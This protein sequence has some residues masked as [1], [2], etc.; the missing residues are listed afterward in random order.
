MMHP[1]RPV[2]LIIFLCLSCFI[3]NAQN[4]TGSVTDTTDKKQVS[5]VVI[6]ILKPVDS[7]L[8]K[9]T[10]TDKEGKFA[11]KNLPEGKYILMMTHPAYADLLDDI[12]LTDKGLELNNLAILP[13]IKLM[14]D[15]IIKSGGSMRIHGD[16]TIF[17]A[18]SFKVSANANVEEL[19]K[20]LPGIQVDKDGKIKAM[21]E[22]VEKVL[23]DGE[24][25]FGDD[26][27][28][29]VKN[30]RA[31]A[32]KEV[33][34]FDKKSD[35]AEFTGIDDG[36]TKKTINLKLK[37]DRKKGYF[38]KIDLS[39]GLNKDFG[40][41][42]NN[43]ILLSSFKGK[44]KISGYFLSGNTGQDGLNW[45]D[46]DKFGGDNDNFSVSADED[47]GI[48]FNWQGSSDD[49]PYVDTQNGF[50]KNNN[51]GLQYSNKWH[52]D[53]Q[54]LSFSPK[55]N[56]QDYINTK[57]TFT[58]T[59]LADSFF[60][61]NG[62][63]NMHVKK[64]TFKLKG[65]YDF[66]I[67]SA[68]SLKLTAKLNAYNTE[69]ES[70]ATSINT[71]QFGKTN[72]TSQRDLTT[73]SDKL[74]F[75]GTL[76]FKHKFQKLR[77]TFSL[78]A[79][80]NTLNT[81]GTNFLKSDNEIYSGGVVSFSQKFDQQKD[82]DRSTDQFLAKAVY[83]E[84]LGK[85]YAL[86][87]D[88]ET[89]I[90]TGKNNQTTHSYSPL[91][92]KYDDEVDS[93]TNL[94]DQRITV[95]KPGFKINYNYKKLKFNIGSGVGFTRFDLK[96]KTFNK[97]YARS[98]TNFFP[99]A[100]LTYA[101]KSGHNL[102]FYYNGNTTQ[103]RIDQLQLLRNNNDYFNQVLGNPLLKPSFSNNFNISHQSFDFIKDFFLYQNLNFTQTSNAITDSRVID[104][105]TGKTTST[106]V[107]TNGNFNFN[108]YAGAGFKMKKLNIR[109]DVGPNAGYNHSTEIINGLNNV[110]KN[111]NAGVRL[112]LNKA[113]DK[114]Y[115]V[116]VSNE[117]NYNSNNTQQYNSKINYY[118]NETGLYATYYLKKVWSLQSDFNYFVR[119]KTPQFQNNLS[120]Q[121]WNAKLQRTFKKDE[122][123]LYF[124]IR[125]ILNQNTGIQRNFYSNTLSEVRQ[126]RLKRYWMLGFTWNFK[127]KAAAPTPTK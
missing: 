41:R 8:I 25:F 92:G 43:N 110:T 15:L 97:D 93:L 88:Y 90:G 86:E 6:A 63:E 7:T 61:V 23:V 37:D 59:Q 116:T 120:N 108:L 28:M 72:N 98:Y 9:F 85:K 53:K 50:F 106:P 30:L 84:P 69:S 4:I 1:F 81:N 80:W 60:N 74:A 57:K 18:D 40:D 112:Y 10:R 126:D 99:N 115:D 68:N 107:N 31:D 89:S 104:A 33:Q 12:T 16:T 47:G 14:Q 45:Q 77:R 24:E 83:T 58:Q 65:V 22:T 26:P 71:N 101:Y 103:P 62:T 96:D 46:N 44:R 48:N 5:N 94:F 113:K 32:V 118:T 2:L 123:T 67:D 49:E 91:S 127:N 13:K 125:D 111:L 17:T 54:G 79:D 38:G 36:K 95:N 21:G 121:L 78:T 102:R 100:N 56:Y 124:S 82:F 114:A 75:N 52:D 105:S 70:Y 11:L 19:L 51:V 122:Y 3:A 42:Y 35:Q 64:E 27:G 29:A 119:Q 73:N 117:F 20:K 66:K 87:L 39:G 76:L 34:V 109:V 55:Y